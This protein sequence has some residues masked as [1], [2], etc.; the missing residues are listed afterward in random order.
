[1]QQTGHYGMTLL[2]YAPVALVLLG[3]DLSGLALFGGALALGLAMVPDCDTL[4]PFLNH[5]GITHTVWFALLMGTVVG[6]TAWIAW[7]GIDVETARTVSRF[8]FAVGTTAVGSHLL[9]DV[10]TPMGIRPLWPLSERHVTF[11]LVL[12]KNWTA[13]VTLFALGAAATIVVVAAA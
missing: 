3:R 11:D 6:A 9:G 13:N 2:L 5:R 7:A 1:M 10:I 12:A 8:S 4:I